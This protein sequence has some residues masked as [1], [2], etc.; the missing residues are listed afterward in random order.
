M[1]TQ[2]GHGERARI[3]RLGRLQRAPY[4][5]RSRRHVEMRNAGLT[6]RVEHCVHQAGHRPG[7]PGLAHAFGAERVGL[8][9]DRMIEEREVVHQ[10]RARHPVVYARAVART[11]A[12]RS[13][14]WIADRKPPAHE[15]ADDEACGTLDVTV[16]S[17]G[18]CREDSAS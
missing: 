13:R 12:I 6:K 16:T 8:G 15:G 11:A 3:A 1:S 17:S 2:L 4:A 14:Y 18:A 9:R 10:E 5:L 7:D